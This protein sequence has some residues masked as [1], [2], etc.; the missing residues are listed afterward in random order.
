MK[1][2]ILFQKIKNGNIET[3]ENSDSTTMEEIKNPGKEILK[4][5]DVK[6]Q[7]S[8]DLETPSGAVLKWRV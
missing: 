8:L 2:L 7:E 1:K 6:A 5:E 3:T 4:E